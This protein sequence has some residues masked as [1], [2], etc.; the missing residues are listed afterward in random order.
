[1]DEKALFTKILGIK[2]PW[3]VKQVITDEAA[4]RRK[5]GT[6]SLSKNS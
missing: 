5:R 1:M 4:Q 2:L 3:F 6:Q